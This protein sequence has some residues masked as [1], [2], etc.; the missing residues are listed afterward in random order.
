MA[1]T[2]SGLPAI[3]RL[4][5]RVIVWRRTDADRDPSTRLV[6]FAGC[7]IVCSLA[8]D[9][10]NGKRF[11]VHR[12]LE[13][14]TRLI[15]QSLAPEARTST[16]E[17]A[18]GGRVAVQVLGG[19]HVARISLAVDGDP[20]ADA[21]EAT[22]V[23]IRRAPAGR[24]RELRGA[25]RQFVDVGRG[26]VRL[27]LPWLLID[28]S[29]LG[30]EIR[31]HAP[32]R[33][34]YRDPFGDRASLVTRLLVEQPARTWSAREL[35]AAAGVSTMTASHVLRQLREIGAVEV[36]RPGR[37]FEARMVNVRAL[38]E[39]WTRAYDWR[40]SSS[41]SIRAPIG[42]PDRFLPRLTDVLGQSRWALTL[43]AGASLV[44]PHAAWETM[45]VYV[46][47]LAQTASHLTDSAGWTV[48][49]GRLVLLQPYYADS[50][51][52]GV[53]AVGSANVVSDLQLILDLW[54]YP[55]RGREQAEVLLQRMERELDE[56]RGRA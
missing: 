52:V 43:Q 34:A 48:G 25:N 50:A 23:V 54:H 55:V 12:D 33:R 39:R 32:A 18:A 10:R 24:L 42:S 26:I 36:R 29:D 3:R 1:G 7:R 16:P 41:V 17:H 49:D 8:N 14:A 37:A 28:R 5:P 47:D 45:H 11:V 19:E 56:A 15:A 40:R 27:R 2:R 4:R 20:I 30:P 53:H 13:R 38:V 31:S 44:A 22:V 51:W 35:A 6:P 21:D 9:H 46:D